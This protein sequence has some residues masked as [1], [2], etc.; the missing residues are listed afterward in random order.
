MNIAR[1]PAEIIMRGMRSALFDKCRRI[2]QLAPGGPNGVAHILIVWIECPEIFHN[3]PRNNLPGCRSPS[4]DLAI[5]ADPGW[6]QN[7]AAMCGPPAR[8]RSIGRLTISGL[9]YCP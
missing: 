3:N 5:R 1:V 9:T 7:A 6:S 2:N 8:W 4:R